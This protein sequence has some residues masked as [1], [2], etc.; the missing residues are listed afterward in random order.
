VGK[1][2]AEERPEL[3]AR[4][5]FPSVT[6]LTALLQTGLYLAQKEPSGPPPAGA[7]EAFVKALTSAM[8]EA[9]RKVLRNA[10]RAAR[11][12]GTPLDVARWMQFADISASRAGL[13]L[14]G[15]L[16]AAR[17]AIAHEAQAPGDAAPREKLNELLVFSVSDEYA[18]LRQ[19]IGVGVRD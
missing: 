11:A 15:T 18:D 9:D 4:A 14:G 10:V 6:E 5:A 3:A 1:P 7:G 12:E 19:A 17:R 16:D 2:L 13:L 8:T